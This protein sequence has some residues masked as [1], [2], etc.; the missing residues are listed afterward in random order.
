LAEES[1]IFLTYLVPSPE[2]EAAKPRFAASAT[3]FDTFLTPEEAQALLGAVGL[4]AEQ[5]TPDYLD[6]LYFR[7]RDDGLRAPTGERF[8]IGFARPHP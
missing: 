2:V 7:D 1:E 8:I 4:R 6:A 3:P 5:F